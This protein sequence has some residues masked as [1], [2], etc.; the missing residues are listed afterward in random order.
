MTHFYGLN[1]CAKHTKL[2]IAAALILLVA[3]CGT[4]TSIQPTTVAAKQMSFM[5]KTIADNMRNPVDTQFRNMQ[6]FRAANGSTIL[7]GEI[8]GTNG[9]GGF[10][11][12]QPMAARFDGQQLNGMDV[13]EL[14]SL[15]CNQAR[16]GTITMGA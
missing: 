14:G 15:W 3:A 13:G 10:T 12:F 5:Q 6:A 2:T 8:N 9:F 7:C 11:G 4:P 16:S 1:F